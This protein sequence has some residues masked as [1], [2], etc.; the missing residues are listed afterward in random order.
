MLHGHYYSSLSLYDMYMMS[1]TTWAA[2][3]GQDPRIT[4]TMPLASDSCR[5]IGIERPIRDTSCQTGIGMPCDSGYGRAVRRLSSVCPSN[6]WC[7]MENIRLMSCSYI[8]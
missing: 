1:I 5:S 6:V 4:K 3:P 2:I 7:Y 8:K